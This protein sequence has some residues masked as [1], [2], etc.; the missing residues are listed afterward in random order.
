MFHPKLNSWL[1][2]Y[3]AD[4]QHPVNQSIHKICVPFIVF[5]VLA[6]LD[7]VALVPVTEGFSLS[8]GHVVATLGMGFYFWLSPKYGAV[9]LVWS[10]L[11]LAL[12]PFIPWWAT[13]ALAAVLWFFQLVGHTFYEHNTPSLTRNAIQALI[14]P[15]FVFSVLLG[16]FPVREP[17]AAK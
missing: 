12:S 17:A 9:M 11:C 10:A 3:A 13:T 6:M 2:E 4:H 8:L 16:D 1:A 15:V 7:W 5:H 14:G